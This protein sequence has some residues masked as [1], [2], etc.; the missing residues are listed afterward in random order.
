MSVHARLVKR[1]LIAL[2]E[3]GVLAWAIHQ[4]VARPRGASHM[5][6]FGGP[7]GHS[8]VVAYPQGR[9]VFLEA[10]SG[11]GRLTLEQQA[12]RARVEGAGCTYIIVSETDDLEGLA[13]RIEKLEAHG[14]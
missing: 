10:K 5:I 1:I 8:D 12:F 11:S 6:R 13:E 2:A 9:A 14:G 7:P 4:G 3:R